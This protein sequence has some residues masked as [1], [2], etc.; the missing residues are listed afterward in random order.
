MSAQDISDNS[1][2]RFED[3]EAAKDALAEPGFEPATSSLGFEDKVSISG[4]GVRAKENVRSTQG[5]DST[6]A[7]VDWD[8][9]TRVPPPADWEND[10]AAFDS[11]FM[12]A[13]IQQD[14]EPSVPRG[15]AV[16]LD[17]KDPK[18]ELA[19]PIGE[20]S[21]DAPIEH[22]LTLPG[23]FNVLHP[24]GHDGHSKA[25]CTLLDF[26]IIFHICRWRNFPTYILTCRQTLRIPTI[27]RNNAA[28][29][30]KSDRRSR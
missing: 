28:T 6:Q 14:W 21:F 23:Q 9:K 17:M 29:L 8:G 7:L 10:R 26:I 27:Q 11:G 24:V 5:E 2:S 30:Q 4:V 22:P 25:R 13:Y 15:P 19:I 16:A 1:L 3:V 20:K 18:F 12:P